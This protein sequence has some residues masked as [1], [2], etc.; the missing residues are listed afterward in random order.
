[1][2]NKI[3][4]EPALSDVRNY[5][6]ERGYRV[7][8]LNLNEHSSWNLRSYGAIVVTGLNTNLSGIHDTETKAAVINA[9]GLTPEEVAAQIDKR[10]PTA[11]G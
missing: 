4:I 3:A 1:M 6:A 10:I 11:M 8:N 7:E 5:L 2:K 9:D